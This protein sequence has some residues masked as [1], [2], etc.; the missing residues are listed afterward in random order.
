MVEVS[1]F[2]YIYNIQIILFVIDKIKNKNDNAWGIVSFY[3]KV[4]FYTYFS[5][6]A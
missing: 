5:S 6:N 2:K 1:D 3:I 4:H